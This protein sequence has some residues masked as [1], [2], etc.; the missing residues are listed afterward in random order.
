MKRLITV[1]SA[2]SGLLALASATAFAAWISPGN[3]AATAQSTTLPAP[4][5]G[6]AIAAG[7]G[8]L[9]LT[10][11]PPT[12]TPSSYLVTNQTAG[13]PGCSSTVPSC[14]VEGLAEGTAYTFTVV[15]KLENWE[16]PASAAFGGT[17]GQTDGVTIVSVTP[18]PVATTDASTVVKWRANIN[19]AYS[20]RIGGTNCTDGTLVT[21][22]GSGD[23]TIQPATV[24]TTVLRTQL[25]DGANTIRVCV[26]AVSATT[27]VTKTAAVLQTDPPSTP[28]LLAADDS[29]TIA[30]ASTDNITNVAKPRFTGTATAGSLVKLYR[31][32]V[33]IGSQQLDA[34]ATS[35]EITPTADVTQGKDIAV[36]A[37]ALAT[38]RTVSPASSALT[39]TFDRTAP[40]LTANCPTAS[41]SY[42]RTSNGSA[43]WD[44]SQKCGG[45]AKFDAADSHSTVVTGAMRIVRGTTNCWT[46]SNG[47]NGS[48]FT[49]AACAAAGPTGYEAGFHA[50]VDGAGDTWTRSLTQASFATGS[51]TFTAVAKDAAGNTSTDLSVS[52]SIT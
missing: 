29:G 20:V 22:N 30:N 33:E 5:G 17:S 31:A 26:G 16:S 44:H 25:A 52:F 9:S 49:T 14:T 2:T 27:T 46:G 42:S 15:A 21:P 50:A 48:T 43:G 28:D 23:Y 19:G 11:N 32:G 37:T 1:A 4:T 51:H 47:T 6:S 3:G 36:T 45:V 24:D 8:K 41:G 13:A 12:P 34:L 18:N 40:T 7:P 35:W 10:W 39:V 38:G